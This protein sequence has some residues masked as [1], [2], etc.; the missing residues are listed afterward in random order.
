[1]KKLVA[2]LLAGVM[3][4]SLAACGNNGSSSNEGSEYAP[5]KIS[6]LGYSAQ[7]VTLNI[8]RD[9]LTKAGFEVEINMQPDYSSMTTVED[10]REWDIVIGGWTTV[11]GNPD[12]AARDIYASYGQYNSGG[13]NDAK[14]DELID[15]AAGETPA[16]YVETYKELEDYL[17]TEMAYTLPLYWQK[18]LRVIDSS[19]VDETTVKNPQSRS[20]FWENYS[21]V[22]ASQNATRTLWMFNTG[23]GGTASLKHLDPIQANDGSINQLSSNI[24]V[25]IINMTEDDQI[26]AD[27]SLS[28][29]YA[30]AEG[31]QAFYF[32]LRDDVFF[33]K[34]ED[35]HVVGTDILVGGEDVVYSLSRAANKETIST[36]GTYN[37]HKHM[38]NISVVTD[39]D[40]LNTV[41][42]SDTGKSIFESLSNGLATPVSELVAADADVDNA[43]GKYQVVKVETAS[44]MPQV[45]YF[46][47][48][49]SAGIL[50]KDQVEAYNSKFDGMAFDPTKDICYGDPAQIKAG[51]NML[52]MSGPYALVEYNDYEVLFEANPGYM[53][54]TEY[55][56]KI[57]NV[58]MKFYKDVAAAGTAFRSGEID[59]MDS[60]N[61]NDVQTFKNEGFTV[62]E[63]VRH[64]TTYAEFN[65]D[66]GKPMADINLRK[67]VLYAIN[68]EDFVAYSE[69]IYGQ[70]YSS[71]STLINTGNVLKQDLEKS[72]EY[73][74]LYNEAHAAQ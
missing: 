42:D 62:F 40:E 30:I 2:L 29:N 38:Q 34:V 24:N 21:Y 43:A 33:S 68:Q 49:Q 9:Q 71:F 66:E 61:T 50:N 58:G 56:P 10:T 37:L 28:L 51:N 27:G 26:E 53:A 15:K 20:A 19:V 14:V 59:I 57:Q 54:G 5:V 65:M 13:I 45:L 73:L 7:E 35:K 22:D 3:M 1:M 52:Y 67:A 41:L 8:L 36:H 55:A 72:A 48:H 16:Q 32:I 31:N 39:M 63:Y 4:F 25:R 44:P 23:S 17:V 60:C 47:A 46:L 70:L 74:K 18:G 6:V 64:A 69:G 12:Y 11:T